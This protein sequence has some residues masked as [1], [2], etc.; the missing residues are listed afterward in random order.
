MKNENS[1]KIVIIVVALIVCAV[2]VLAGI[3]LLGKGKELTKE[4]KEEVEKTTINYIANMTGG[5]GTVFGGEDV[6]FSKADK[7]TYKDLEPVFILNAAFNYS[8]DNGA[9]I[10]STLDS[11]VRRVYNYSDF[12]AFKGEDV[13]KAVKELFGEDFKNADAEFFNYDYVFHYDSEKDLYIRTYQG[14]SKRSTDYL[15]YVSPVATTQKKD[16]VEVEVVVAYV[17]GAGGYYSFTKDS[18]LQELVFESE[19]YEMDKE[20]IDKFDH[21]V[22]T[23]KVD[24]DKKCTFES[25]VK[26]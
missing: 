20:K 8:V 23:Y 19:K 2:L 3:K 22:I 10:D 26:K 12:L 4:K 1:K 16:K 9:S 14:A 5:M 13:R 6:L 25:I 7:Q 21:F 18:D 17:Y 24:K 11:Y 15:V